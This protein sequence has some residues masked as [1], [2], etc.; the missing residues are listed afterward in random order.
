[1]TIQHVM[2]DLETMGNGP[3][4]AI[5]AIGAVKFDPDKGEIVETFYFKVNLES[6][7]KCGGV[8]DASTIIWWL[9]Q[10]EEARAEMQKEG[11]HINLSLDRFRMWL[12]DNGQT[13]IWGNGAA[14]DNVILASA[15][16]NSGLTVPWKFIGDRCYRT[17]KTM[18]KQTLKAE[19]PTIKHHALAD[20]EAQAKHLMLIAKTH[21]LILT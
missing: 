19:Q 4:A 13:R 7:V 11:E 21:G 18:F 20:A 3:N 9:G 10:N 14:F 15:Y 8:I 6:S 17:V 16:K 2:L 1:M 12:G 5:T